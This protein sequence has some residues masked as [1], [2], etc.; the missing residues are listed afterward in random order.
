MRTVNHEVNAGVGAGARIGL[1]GW[2]GKPTSPFPAMRRTL[3]LGC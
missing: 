2:V 3:R 1:A